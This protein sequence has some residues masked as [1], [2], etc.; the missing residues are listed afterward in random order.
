MRYLV[1]VTVCFLLFT[2]YGLSEAVG[3][4]TVDPNTPSAISTRSADAKSGSDA[5][6]KQRI[7]YQIKQGRLHDIAADLSKI[8]YI[9][10][11]TDKKADD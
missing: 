9:T 4:L 1:L 11:Y 8:T 6:L 2:E 7:N 3:K 10:I 5:R